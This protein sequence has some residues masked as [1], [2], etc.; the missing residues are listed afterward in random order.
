MGHAGEGM[1]DDADTLTAAAAIL[2]ARAHD[3]R[4][5]AISTNV[6]ERNALRDRAARL[7]RAAKLLEDESAVD[8][9]STVG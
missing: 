6:R 8:G 1:S 3:M 4:V 7:E 9:P 5:R 2:K